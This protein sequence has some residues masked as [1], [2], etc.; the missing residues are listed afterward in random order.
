MARKPKLPKDYDDN[1]EWTEET[2]ARSVPIEA[3]PELAALFPKRGRPK[4]KVRKVPVSLRLSAEVVD[5]FKT[6]IGPGWQTAIDDLL[7]NVKVSKVEGRALKGAKRYVFKPRM[8]DIEVIVH[9]D[10]GKSNMP[11]VAKKRA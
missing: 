9:G 4:A 7:M 10:I 2:T 11:H 8:A 3:L 6:A 1:P 5:K